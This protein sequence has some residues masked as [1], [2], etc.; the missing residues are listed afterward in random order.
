M[1]GPQ[2]LFFFGGGG[3]LMGSK[4]SF[5]FGGG[6]WEG[7]K[8][9]IYLCFL[10]GGVDFFGQYLNDQNHNTIFVKTLDTTIW[11]RVFKYFE[12][13]SINIFCLNCV[14]LNINVLNFNSEKPFASAFKFLLLQAINIQAKVIS[15][16]Y[17][18]C[19]SKVFQLQQP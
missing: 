3:A 9:Y 13:Y 19:C 10:R 14:S 8:I 15:S 6:R 4:K 17:V 12:Y 1:E 16:F 2:L 18:C 5:F 7:Q 11:C